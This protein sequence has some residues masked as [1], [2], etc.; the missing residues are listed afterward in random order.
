MSAFFD[1]RSG[2]HESNSGG[3]ALRVFGSFLFW[4][5]P[6][7]GA[8]AAGAGAQHV[9]CAHMALYVGVYSACDL[10]AGGEGIL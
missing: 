5:E 3:S 9:I 7:G 1:F 10:D 8:E 2:L 4:H 6:F